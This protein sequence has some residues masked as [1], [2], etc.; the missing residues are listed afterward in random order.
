MNTKIEG[1]WED[2]EGLHRTAVIKIYTESLH[3]VPESDCLPWLA[4][5]AI[6]TDSFVAQ[7]AGGFHAAM[8]GRWDNIVAQAPDS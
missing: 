5:S 3:S 4:L 6:T 8:C 7:A 2:G 1:L